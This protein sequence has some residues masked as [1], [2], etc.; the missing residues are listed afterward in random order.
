MKI[1]QS[2]SGTLVDNSD[3]STKVSWIYE[4]IL[5]VSVWLHFIISKAFL[6]QMH[7]KNSF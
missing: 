4:T 2:A 6:L 7:P 5:A 3:A 1:H